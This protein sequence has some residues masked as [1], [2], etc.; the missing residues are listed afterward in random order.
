MYTNVLK[1]TAVVVKK[2]S[3]NVAQDV[4]WPHTV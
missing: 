3:M 1:T 4:E 2:K